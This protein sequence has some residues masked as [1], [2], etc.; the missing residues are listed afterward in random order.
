MRGVPEGA[1]V[2]G[3]T[4]SARHADFPADYSEALTKTTGQGDSFGTEE[5]TGRHADLVLV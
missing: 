1:A 5:K 2:S 3:S 4:M